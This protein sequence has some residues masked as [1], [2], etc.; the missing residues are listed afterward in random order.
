MTKCLFD[1]DHCSGPA[2]FITEKGRP[3]CVFHT[4]LLNDLH[5]EPVQVN[6]KD[7]Y[8]IICEGP[9]FTPGQMVKV[10]MFLEEHNEYSVVGE[11][12]YA[13]AKEIVDK[14]NEE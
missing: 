3:L 13:A 12:H 8:A 14:M 10:A 5:T 6:K 11:L 4:D 1:N 7:R 9:I 2:E